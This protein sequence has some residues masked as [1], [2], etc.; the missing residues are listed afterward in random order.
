VGVELAHVACEDA[1]AMG[2][3][4]AVTQPLEGRRAA[5][6]SPYAQDAE[7]AEP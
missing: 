3:E 5:T 2:V 7:G 4:L 1:E 6:P